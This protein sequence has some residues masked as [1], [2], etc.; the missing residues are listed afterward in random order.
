MRAR[1]RSRDDG[2]ER[3]DDRAR[4]RWARER[5]WAEDARDGDRGRERRDRGRD[6]DWA[7]RERPRARGRSR[8]SGYRSRAP[9]ERRERSR[10]GA[11]EES[12]GRFGR[13]DEGG[14]G[15]DERD[16]RERTSPD[17]ER[18]RFGGAPRRPHAR[19]VETREALA[20]QWLESRAVTY[21]RSRN[22]DSERARREVHVGN[23]VSGQIGATTLCE[24]MNIVLQKIV[25]EAC[26][27]VGGLPPV[28]SIIMDTH[29][30]YARLEMRS[31]ALATAALGLDQMHV[32]GRPLHITRPS[33]YFDD[34][35][36][37]RSV[38][39]VKYVLP[40]P[41]RLAE[42]NA[43]LDKRGTAATA[44]K[45]ETSDYAKKE[46]TR[47]DASTEYLCLEN[48]VDIAVLRSGRERKDLQYDVEDE[49]SKCGRVVR[50]F[51]QS[52]RDEDIKQNTVSRVFVQFERTS[53]SESAYKMMQ[54][55]TFGGRTVTARYMNAT[56][57]DREYHSRRS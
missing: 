9:Y 26:R 20:E 35:E 2:R 56:E 42:V 40:A 27:A 22:A 6:D 14:G 32:V 43:E 5:W 18:R 38:L 17:E 19:E 31:A 11:R 36:E 33:R 57:F 28:L 15:R 23:L 29:Q 51:V 46:E 52:P 8:E 41:E 1:S 39:D 7:R 53:S 48:M 24:L 10:D 34:P 54:G 12:G 13:R 3:S 16:A 50:V 30:K 49:C 25:P 44:P 4:E 37:K 47:A 45:T 21:E 55:R